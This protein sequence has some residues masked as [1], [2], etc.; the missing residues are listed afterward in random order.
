MS[1]RSSDS[2]KKSGGIHVEGGWRRHSSSG[3]TDDHHGG[4]GFSWTPGRVGGIS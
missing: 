3:Q 2:R 1:L 4:A